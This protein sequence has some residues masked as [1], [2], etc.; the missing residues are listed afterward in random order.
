[1]R[2]YGAASI[3]NKELVFGCFNVRIYFVD[4]ESGKINASFQ[5]E[6]SKKYYTA[7]FDDKDKVKKDIDP[8]GKNYL[9]V[10]KRILALGAI[11]STPTIEHDL[12]YF[13]DSNGFFYALKR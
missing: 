4:P 9:E 2:V 11:L 12:L 10:E 8:D 6:E 13:G 3:M 7:L 5:T 1:M